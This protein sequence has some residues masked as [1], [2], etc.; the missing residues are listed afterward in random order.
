[1]KEKK[2]WRWPLIFVVIALTIYNILPS[3]FYYAQPLKSPL[4]EKMAK[5][6]FSSMDERARALEPESIE[7]LSSYCDLLQIKPLSIEKDSEVPQLIRLKFTKQE[8]AARFKSHVARAGA[9]IPFFPSQLTPLPSE[10]KVVSVLKRA[11]PRL[12]ESFFSYVQKFDE[13][14]VQTQEYSNLILDRAAAVSAAVAGTS[15]SA[16]LLEKENL[17]ESELHQ[18]ASEINEI[19]E[20]PGME[21]KK[22][23]SGRFLGRSENLERLLSLFSSLRD[24]LKLQKIESESPVKLIE[25]KEALLARAEANLKKY[26]ESFLTCEKPLSFESALKAFEK[27][28]GEK[29]TFDLYSISPFFESVEIDW[30][31][32]TFSLTLREEIKEKQALFEQLLINEVARIS[33]ITGE[34]F[35]SSSVGFSFSLQGMQDLSGFLVLN[36]GAISDQMQDDLIHLLKKEWSPKHPDLSL[37]RFPIVSKQEFDALPDLKKQIC[38]VVHSPFQDQ[39]SFQRSFSLEI[40]GLSRLFAAANQGSEEAKEQ[41]QQDLSLLASLLRASGFSEFSQTGIAEFA[42]PFRNYLAALREEFSVRG[43]KRFALIECSDLAQRILVQNRIETQIHEDL[44]KWQDEWAQAQVS[45]NPHVRFDVPKPTKNAFMS[46]LSL[47]FRK[48]I[49]GDERRIVRWGLDLSGGKTVQI[50]LR[51][52][53][54]KPV[55]DESDVKQGMSELFGRV[56]KMG[57]SEVAI[58]QLGNTIVLDFPSSQALSAKELVASSSMSFHVV[59]EKFSLMSS[60]LADSVNRFLQE[61]WNEA[62]VTNRKDPVSINAIAR[63]RLQGDSDAARTLVENGLRLATPE[64]GCSGQL[65]EVLSK[66]I[67]FRGDQFLDWH[68]QTHP[69]LIVFNNYALEG[70]DLT[71]IHSSYDP[72]KG[73]FLSF[74]VKNSARD[75]LHF[76]TLKFSKENLSQSHGS[77]MAVVLNDSC[78]SCPVLNSALRESA[79]ISGNFSQREVQKLA[80]DLKAGSLTFTPFILSEKNV[81]PELGSADRS[82]GIV[83]M[84]VSFIFVVAAM[85]GY[86]RFAGIVASCAVFFNLLI[87]WAALQNIQAALTLSGIAGIILTVAMA[88]DAN[89]LVFERVKEEFAIT[90]DLSLALDAGYKKAFSAIFDSNITTIIAALILLN[91]NAGP[92]KGFAITLIIGMVSSLFTALFMTRT[93]FAKWVKKTSRKKLRMSHWI[94]SGSF[95]FLKKARYVFGAAGLVVVVGGALF[96]SHRSTIFGI[97]F[98]GG[99]SASFEVEGLSAGDHDFASAVTAAFVKEGALPRDF[100]V[101]SL[102]PESNVRVL[103]SPNADV[104]RDSSTEGVQNW[105]FHA[106]NAH[107]LSLTKD[108][109]SKLDNMWTAMSGQMSGAMRNSAIIGLLLAFVSIFIYL[110]VRFEATFAAAALLCLFLELLVTFAIIGLLH[111]GG[112]GIQID[113]NTIAALMTM[114]GY[115]LNDVI[116]IFDRIRE[117]LRHN[118]NRPLALIV[119]HALNATLGRTA[120]TSGITF[121]VLL[122]LVLLGGPSLLSFSLVMALGVL[123]GTISSWFIASPLFLSFQ[124]I[125]DRRNSH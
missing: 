102:T 82:A 25:K 84:A 70:S 100:Q 1:M 14:G 58:R 20:L 98:S 22:K 59:N 33:R 108:S 31:Q 83:A 21:L 16:L 114:V 45:F 35:K 24:R 67:L 125:S 74:D 62:V 101:R 78:I 5:N 36:L 18:L 47:T 56:N 97:D 27:L 28:D 65:S 76:W 107:G 117:E 3:I 66:I 77:R 42:E 104:V 10:G 8:E 94:K 80:S 34:T 41:L 23:L 72:S 6:A 48:L 46:N 38:L 105:M 106:L 13:R 109:L 96:F 121:F 17:N 103:F 124:R 44:L 55:V 39:N 87:L 120:I 93:Y 115:C 123:I 73:N 85:V 32:G 30:R 119:N 68:H 71:N 118:R 75:Q 99:V 116:I 110:M 92:I 69:L 63:N 64:E 60:D 11:A 26:R 111:A 37:D 90:Q 52:Q 113:L 91:F 88:V 15:D 53:N 51:D 7:W 79:M 19:S 57:V 4:T 54:G 40:K 43:S 122:I 49:R 95:D 29:R 61:V 12:S 81:S 112:L 89:V 9:L 2:K 86:Y 50:E